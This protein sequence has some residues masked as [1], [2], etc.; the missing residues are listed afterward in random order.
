MRS[1]TAA[2][3][4]MAAMLG[5]APAVF[6]GE[7]YGTITEGGKPVGEGVAVE[8]KCAQGAYSAKTDKSGTYHLVTKENGKCQLTVRYKN[9]S[10]GIDVASYDEGV[11]VDLVLES[12]GGNYTVRRK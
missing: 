5:L 1:K 11:Q 10:P 7:V 4:L 6:A 8:A 2:G 3:I 12:K 9:Q